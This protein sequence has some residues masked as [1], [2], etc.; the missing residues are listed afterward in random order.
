MPN[1]NCAY[2]LPTDDSI[3]LFNT[4]VKGMVCMYEYVSPKKRLHRT[5]NNDVDDV[6]RLKVVGLKDVVRK[7]TC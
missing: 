6:D 5:V 3:N 2:C 4:M 1:S 7:F